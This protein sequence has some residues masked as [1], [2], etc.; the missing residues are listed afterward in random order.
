MGKLTIRDHISL[1]FIY[2]SI[3]IMQFAYFLSTE[4]GKDAI[5][6]IFAEDI[7]TTKVNE[8]EMRG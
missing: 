5:E 4:W 2:S 6:D 8:K 7:F 3:I 1:P